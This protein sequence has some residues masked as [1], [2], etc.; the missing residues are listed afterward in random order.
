M[1]ATMDGSQRG[2][3]VA[4]LEATARAV[5]PTAPEET[6]AVGGTEGVT[7]EGPSDAAAF[8]EKTGKELSLALTSEGRHPSARDEPPL[9]WVSPWD[10][11]SELFTLDDAAEGM[12]QEKLREGFTTALEAPNQASSALRDVIVPTGQVFNWLCL[13]ISFFL[14]LFLFSDHHL[15]SVTYCSQPGEILVPS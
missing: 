2:A 10:L 12:E 11:S 3:V 1:V 6:P 15:F 13:P 5:S 14:H 4:A 7:A 8:A 9:R